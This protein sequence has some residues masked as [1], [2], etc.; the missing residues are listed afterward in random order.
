[1]HSIQLS[2]KESTVNKCSKYVTEVLE[3]VPLVEFMY[4]VI[5]KL[6]RWESYHRR[7]GYLLLYLCFVF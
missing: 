2:V 6:A 3:D 1:M 4:L 7:L 5:Y